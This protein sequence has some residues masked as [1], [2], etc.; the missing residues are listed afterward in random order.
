MRSGLLVKWQELY[1]KIMW[2]FTVGLYILIPTESG[3]LKLIYYGIHALT[4]VSFFAILFQTRLTSRFNSGRL[5]AML[6]ITIIICISGLVSEESIS[7]SEHFAGA[8]GFLEI[9]MAIYIIDTLDYNERLAKFVYQ[10]NFLVSMVFIALYFSP[11]AYTSRIVGSLNLGYSNPNVAAIYLLLNLSIITAFFDK[12]QKAI[13]KLIHIALL[14]ALVY[15][16]FLTKSR[17]CLLATVAILAYRF[18]LPKWKIPK[19]L[20]LPVQ[21][22]PLVFLFGYVYVFKQGLV[23][24]E[25]FLGKEFFSG[26]EGFFV[27][28]LEE[29]KSTWLIGNFGEHYFQNAHNGPLAIMLNIGVPGYIAYFY[30][31]ARTVDTYYTR[32]HT[33]Q[34][35]LALITLFAIFL[36]ACAEAALFVGGSNYSILVATIY[37]ILKGDNCSKLE[38]CN[39]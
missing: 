3:Y 18:V 16:I 28:S 29:I 36:H 12:K 5:G 9:M 7:F 37:W 30:F 20:L 33:Y 26:R 31:T 15:M 17:M 13:I 11:Y 1:F 32:I 27:D 21:L 23:S 19:W 38:A 14:S 8:L 10:I 25:L 35:M 2:I 39:E 4:V 34:Q 22:V 6:F 24:D